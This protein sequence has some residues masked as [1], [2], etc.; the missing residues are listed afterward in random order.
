[1]NLKRQGE[2]W[3]DRILKSIVIFA[4]VGLVILC[5]GAYLVNKMFQD[6]LSNVT[7]P[8]G[9]PTTHSGTK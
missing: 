4:I 2:A 6:I 5:A 1:M 8:G 9:T 7:N 3:L